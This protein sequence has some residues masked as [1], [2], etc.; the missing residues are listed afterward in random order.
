MTFQGFVFSEET[1][2]LTDDEFARA[3]TV[4]DWSD[5]AI[6]R[7]DA[8]AAE[9]P[10]SVPVILPDAGWHPE[11]QPSFELDGTTHNAQTSYRLLARRERDIVRK[12]RLYGHSFTG[13]QL[14]TLDLA[15]R[16][17]WVSRKLPD[18]WDNTLRFLAGRPDQSVLD[19]VSVA[20]ALPERLRA[21]PPRKFGEIGWLI[22]GTIVSDDTQSYQ[23]RLC[24][25]Y[26]NGLID[27]LDRRLA[28]RSPLRVVEIGGGYGGLA[29]HLMN[30]FERKLRYAIVDIPESLAFAG[31]Y[32][33]TLFPELDN[34]FVGESGPI[35]LPDTPGFTFIANMDHGRLNLGGSDADLALNTLSLS[36]MSDAQIED[37]CKAVS[38]W[39]GERGIFFEQNHQSNHQGPGNVPPRFLKLLHK[40]SSNLLSESFPMRRGD[41]NFWVNATY[42][43]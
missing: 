6:T 5:E 21:R 9:Y 36:E 34:V 7:R 19:Y 13:Y 31:I 12:M 11:S 14:A 28:E 17:P 30:A 41:A 38:S 18:D 39:I 32:L 37:Y 1:S 25:M 23:E 27:L 24:L 10:K 16:R 40:C 43:G 35:E 2:T 15:E 42:R 3:C 22:D 29:Y 8:M 20:G 33:S 4:L 26:E